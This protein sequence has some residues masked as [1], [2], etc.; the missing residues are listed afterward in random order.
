MVSEWLSAG[1]CDVLSERVFEQFIND[2]MCRVNCAHVPMK[3][4]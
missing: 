4:Q 1:W 2:F 3:Q